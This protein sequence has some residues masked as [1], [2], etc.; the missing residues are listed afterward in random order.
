MRQP[1]VGLYVASRV[2]LGVVFLLHSAASRRP[3]QPDGMSPN[4]RMLAH[5]PILC[6]A[7]TN[8]RICRRDGC[9]AYVL[10]ISSGGKAR[11]PYV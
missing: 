4:V 9:N 7:L 3:G 10:G 2:V 5:H 8:P 11:A 6:F 1:L